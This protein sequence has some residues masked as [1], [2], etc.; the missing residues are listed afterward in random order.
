MNG[1][2]ALAAQHWAARCLLGL[3]A[4][5]AGQAAFGAEPSPA[6]AW[7][8]MQVARSGY[9]IAALASHAGAA[10]GLKY[11]VVLF[12]GNPGVLQLE[13]RDG[14]VGVPTHP[15]GGFRDVRQ[16]LRRHPGQPPIELEVH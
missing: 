4:W 14:E 8:V 10:P 5:V 16:C 13:E 11:G 1:E 9:T 7:S 12:P 3:A 6:T 15:G 2:S